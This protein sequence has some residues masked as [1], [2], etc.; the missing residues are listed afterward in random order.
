MTLLEG[1]NALIFGVANKNS[2]AWGIAQAMHAQGAN[3]AFSYAIPQLEKRVRPLAESVGAKL[4]EECDVTDDAALDRVFDRFKELHGQLD[5]LVH[6]VAYADR[7]DLMGRYV[8]T[9]RENFA[10]TLEISA[11]SLVAVAQRAEPLMSSGGAIMTM[12][13]HGGVAV[14]PHYNVMGVA[15]AALD[16]SVR[17]LAH[18]LGPKGIRVN[19]ISAGPIKTLAASGISGFRRMLSY[20]EKVAPLRTVVTQEDVGHTAVWL[21]SDWSKHVT[22]EIVYVDAG[23]NI[24]GMTVPFDDLTEQ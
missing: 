15:K 17:Y 2:I 18:D 5:I 13:Y 8:D 14:M 9:K 11:Y 20:H 12:T 16:A 21:C 23:W 22:G 24:M 4:I 7:E 6:A 1:K 3:L 10:R 19:A